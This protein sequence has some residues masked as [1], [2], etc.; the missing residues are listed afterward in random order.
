LWS[1]VISAAYFSVLK[2]MDRFRVGAIYEIIGM[3][4]LMHASVDNLGNISKDTILKIGANS[5]GVIKVNK[6]N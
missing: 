6:N 1:I 3:D 4:I 5:D 2:K